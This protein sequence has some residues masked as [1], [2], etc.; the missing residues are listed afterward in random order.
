ME[1]EKI[2][3]RHWRDIAMI[4]FL[5]MFIIL[6]ISFINNAKAISSDP[7]RVCI[8]TYDLQCNNFEEGIYLNREVYTEKDKHI[9]MSNPNL[10]VILDGREP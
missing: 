7:C 5:I 10:T 2:I 4:V 6:V 9:L 3:K 8:E 1:L